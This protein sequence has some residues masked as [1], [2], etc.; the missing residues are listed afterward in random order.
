MKIVKME[1]T[2]YKG[3]QRRRANCLPLL[4]LCRA[5]NQMGRWGPIIKFQQQLITEGSSIS[6]DLCAGRL[7]FLPPPPLF[8]H[9]SEREKKKFSLFRRDII[10]NERA[11]KICQLAY[12]DA[13]QS[14]FTNADREPQK[15]QNYRLLK[16]TRNFFCLEIRRLEE[17]RTNGRNV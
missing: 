12:H 14:L 2:E 6:L 4:M 7:P 11:K 17:K 8:A 13:R 15:L 3:E 16:K 9:C 5:I 10:L 1:G